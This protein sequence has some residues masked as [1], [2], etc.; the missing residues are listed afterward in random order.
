LRLINVAEESLTNVHFK[1]DAIDH[2]LVALD[3]LNEA[4]NVANDGSIFLKANLYEGKIFKDVIMNKTK[5][6]TC[7]QKSYIFLKQMFS[8][9]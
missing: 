1:D 6:Q 5:V 8:S 3:D 9:M 7:F 2:A 4:K